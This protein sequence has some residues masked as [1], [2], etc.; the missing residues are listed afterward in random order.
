MASSD[1]DLSSSPSSNLPVEDQ[2]E[3]INDIPDQPRED[4]PPVEDQVEVINN[5]P[6]QPREDLLDQP[7]EDLPEEDEALAAQDDDVYSLDS[8]I[9][10]GPGSSSTEL[11]ETPP[12]SSP[13]TLE[14]Q[15]N[16]RIPLRTRAAKH[17]ISAK[18]TESKPPSPVSSRTRAALAA[19][20]RVRDNEVKPGPS[21]I[22]SKLLGVAPSVK[23]KDTSSTSN[24]SK[25]GP[26][27]IKRKFLGVALTSKKKLR[28]DDSSSDTD[29]SSSS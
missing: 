12:S 2:V 18:Q 26:S 16:P 29:D 20:R 23:K 4:L 11:P 24:E 25:P 28:N 21:G 7:R 22:K 19:R 8:T 14:V 17:R 15:V 9:I 10:M 27:G 3:V 5:I 13:T 1:K 6:E